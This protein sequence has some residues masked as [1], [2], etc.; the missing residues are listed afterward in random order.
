MVHEYASVS[1][2]IIWQTVERNL[3][4]LVPMLRE[5]LKNEA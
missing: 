5:I 3:P 2:P 1:I 4:P